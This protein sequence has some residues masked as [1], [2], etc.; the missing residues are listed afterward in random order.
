LLGSPGI[1][2]LGSSLHGTG[3]YT[4]ETGGW[5]GKLGLTRGGGSMMPTA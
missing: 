1:G 2:S 5:L 4:P 3:S